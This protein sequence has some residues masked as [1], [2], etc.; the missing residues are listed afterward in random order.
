MRA[1]GEVPE[2]PSVND[3]PSGEVPSSERTR[4]LAT[5][6]GFFAALV[7][8]MVRSSRSVRAWSA[9]AS[10]AIGSVI[11]PLG[12]T[13]IGIVAVSFLLGYARGWLELVVVAW[14]GL[15]LLGGALL[16]LIGSNAAAIGLSLTVDRVSAGET[17]AGEIAV[18]NPVKRRLSGVRV[19][20]P[21]GEGLAVCDVPSIAPG[22]RHHD[23]FTVPTN[24]RGVILIGPVRTVRADPIGLVRRE[25]VWA[26]SLELFVHPR[27]I[28]IPSMSTG[29]MR[30]LEGNPTRDL[31]ASDVSF[32]A[33]REYQPGDERRTIHWKSTAKTGTYMVRQFEETRRSHLIIALSLASGD[34]E[35]A[36]QFELAV[37]A[38]GSLGARAIYD[39]RTVSVLVGDT[40]PEFARKRSF[41]SQALSTVTRSRLLDDLAR[42][43]EHGSSLAVDELARVAADDITGISLAFLVCGSAPSITRLRAASAMFP[44]RVTVIAIVCDPG[45]MPGFARVADLRI[46]TI[47]YLEDLQKSL[48]KAA[49]G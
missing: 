44:I 31:T 20:V 46:L 47:G 36:E 21:I 9:R 11:T 40:T 26:D 37:S 17:A 30:D 25:I 19:E 14:A 42:I 49:N 3:T 22:E 45:A 35:D 48:A 41:T 27:T 34:Y 12:W 8:T 28:S 29:F 23:R 24:R 43:D 5:R 6:D 13:L 4:P 16:Q 38:T 10:S 2:V 15:V 39:A 1:P 33:I 7:V 18:S 32:H